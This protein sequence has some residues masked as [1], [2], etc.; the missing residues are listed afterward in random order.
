MLLWSTLT[1]AILAFAFGGKKNDNR[2]TYDEFVKEMLLKG[3]VKEVVLTEKGRIYVEVI[4]GR[5]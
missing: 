2:I 4:D 3:H 5:N 1:A